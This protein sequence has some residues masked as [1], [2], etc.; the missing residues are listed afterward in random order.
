MPSLGCIGNK[1]EDKRDDI[2]N[3]ENN[4][5]K[6]S[7]QFS[8]SYSNNEAETVRMESDCIVHEDGNNGQD[9]DIPLGV[10]PTLYK[11]KQNKHASP[12]PDATQTTYISVWLLLLRCCGSF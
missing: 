10:H 5:S 7:L 1:S 8:A 9:K 6:V 3:D 11:C 2:T 4:Q 12:S